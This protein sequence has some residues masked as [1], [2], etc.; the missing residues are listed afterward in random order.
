M[1][2]DAPSYPFR[3]AWL[4][5]TVRGSLLVL[6]S[7][8]LVPAVLLAGYCVR[9]LETTLE[10]AEEPPPLEG[11]REL[12]R[13]GVGAVAIACCYL[14]GPL[15]AGAV[16]GAVLGGVGY[17]A[18]GVLAPLVTS[19][20]AI[21][22]VSLVAAAIAALLA[23]VFVAVTLVIYYLLPAALAVYA[24]TRTVRAAF[25]RSTLQ[26]IALSGRYFLSM[27]VLQLLPLVVPVVAVVCLLTVVG[28]VVL[29]AIPFVAALVSFRL[30][31]VAVAEAGGHVVDT[32]ERVAE[33]V[34]AD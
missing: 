22:G 32:H 21:W 25:D 33:R 16:A 27:A 29:P 12:S 2:D 30:I 34:P 13:R 19:E 8:L 20:T 17:F 31:G 6:G 10:G 28:I 7:V 9:V 18:L 14:V 3:G 5:R 23:L 1:L 11:W 24:R 15:V 4:D 26:G